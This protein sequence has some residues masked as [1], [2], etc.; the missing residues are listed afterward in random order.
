Q[1]L[2]LSPVA[3]QALLKDRDVEVSFRRLVTEWKSRKSYSSCIE[4]LGMDL[5]YQQII[6]LGTDAVPFILAELEREPD[7]WFWALFAITGVDPVPTSS[8]G[9]VHEMRKAWLKWGM[10]NG[11]RWSVVP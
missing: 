1:I 2:E 10:Q 8:R 3:T 11:Y 4:D 5:A 9:K 7:H 6:G